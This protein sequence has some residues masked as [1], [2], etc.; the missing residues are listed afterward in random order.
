MPKTLIFKVDRLPKGSGGV[1]FQEQTTNGDKPIIGTIY[2]S[3][4]FV[5]TLGR[6]ADLKVT[7]DATPAA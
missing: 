2:V 6:V 5:R 7:I 4:D 3:Q 1:R